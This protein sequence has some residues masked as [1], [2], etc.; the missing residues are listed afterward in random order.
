MS[1]LNDIYCFVHRTSNVSNELVSHPKLNEQPFAFFFEQDF[2][3]IV[4]KTSKVSKIIIKKYEAVLVKLYQKRKN[5]KKY[6]VNLLP[7]DFIAQ[8]EEELMRKGL[9]YE[10]DNLLSVK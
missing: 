5:F 7:E 1:F 4:T 3:L 10:I 8:Q 2:N 6:F 9:G